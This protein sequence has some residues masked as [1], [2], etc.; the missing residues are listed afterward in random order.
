MANLN[1]NGWQCFT[2]HR[3]RGH[4]ETAPPFAVPYE[5][6]EARFSHR[7]HR[8]SNPRSSCGSPLHY[9]CAMPAP[10]TEITNF[11]FDTFFLQFVINLQ[12]IIKIGFSVDSYISFSYKIVFL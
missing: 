1:R 5:G 7:S 2:S 11:H 10:Q 8:E 12:L 6:R 3:Q 9:L 4:L